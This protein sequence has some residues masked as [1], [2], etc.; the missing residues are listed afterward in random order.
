M[1]EHTHMPKQ[2]KYHTA[3]SSYNTNIKDDEI[4]FIVEQLLDKHL[5][6]NTTK[7]VKKFLFSCLDLTSLNSNDTD[8]SI[9]KMTT[10]VNRFDDE[11][12]D[13]KNVAAICVY[14]A[15]VE[16]VKDTL[17][18]E[19]VRIASV[20]GGFPSGQTFTEVKIAEVSMA[21]MEGADE[22]DTVMPVGKFLSGDYENLCDEL[23]E[24]KESCRGK[25]LKVILETGMLGKVSNIKKAAILAMYSGADFIKTS[26]GKEATGATP[27]AVFVMCE[28]VKEYNE[29]TGT[30]VG[31]KAAG[32]IRT[33]R[34]AIMYYTIVKEVLGKE[35]L[36][37][38][39]FRIG[40]SSLSKL[41]LSEL[42]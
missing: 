27:E 38:E 36:S 42:N 24:I 5:A 8:E 10:A 14:P 2:D 33:V 18:V 12:P 34:D 4:K 26:T 19:N 16:I 7:E 32:G 20:A 25:R 28:A 31:I 15:F 21:I 6:E 29:K 1:E 17:E 41:L 13:L 22:I 3:L 23:E 35:W 37:N 30:R 11:H 40:S 39:L 9:L